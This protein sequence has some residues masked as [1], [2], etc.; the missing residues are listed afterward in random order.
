M[1]LYHIV[2]GL[3]M[4]SFIT[5][6]SYR[7][8]IGRNFFQSSSCVNC[9]HALA[10]KDLIPVISYVLLL[11]K[12]RYCK[13]KISFRYLLIE[14]FVTFSYVYALTYHDYVNLILLSIL[15]VIMIVDIEHYIIPD[16]LQAMLLLLGVYNIYKGRG[17]Y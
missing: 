17:V 14:V 10:W 16:F 6:Y 11:G 8:P 7:L 5:M 2:I 4:G 13:K 1:V 15:I 3:I 9:K 12:C